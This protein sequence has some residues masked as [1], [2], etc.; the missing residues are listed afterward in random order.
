MDNADGD[1]DP[2]QMNLILDALDEAY[3]HIVVVG[4]HDEA[5]KLFEAIEGRL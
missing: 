3:D 1:I 4:R 5:R 2:D